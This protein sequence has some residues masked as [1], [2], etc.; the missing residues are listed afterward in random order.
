MLPTYLSE[1]DGGCVLSLRV[2][3][4]ARKTEIVGVQGDDL[5]LKVAAPPVDGAANKQI[6][7]FLAKKVLGVSRSAVTIVT[8]ER[9][10]SK[11]VHVRA[12]ASDIATQVAKHL[13]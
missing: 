4:G 8:G 11:R 7:A 3:P 6:I 13:P 9:G 2:I 12:P 1:A 10:R 5:K